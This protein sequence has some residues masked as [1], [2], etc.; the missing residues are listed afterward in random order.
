MIK[1]KEKSEKIKEERKGYGI[2]PV[3]ALLL[4]LSLVFLVISVSRILENISG[5]QPLIWIILILSI[6][7]IPV[8]P[9]G[10]LKRKKWGLIYA[11]LVSIIYTSVSIILLV[12]TGN[13]II[14][15]PLFIL[16][17]LSLISLVLSSTRQH[18]RPIEEVEEKRVE[19]DEELLEETEEEAYKHGEFTLYKKMVPMKSGSTRVFYFFSKGVSDKGVPCSLPEGYEVH[20]NKKSGVPYLKKKR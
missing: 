17:F 14:W 13:I 18:F 20:I 11:F 6:I 7:S 16:T 2:K 4:F 1:S 10:F 5:L 3:L 15:Y 19:I 8:I 9:Y 12:S